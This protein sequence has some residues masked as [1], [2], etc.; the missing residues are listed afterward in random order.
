MWRGSIEPGLSPILR[1]PSVEEEGDGG[2]HR[3]ELGELGLIQ[4]SLCS[5]FGNHFLEMSYDL[6]AARHHRFNF[7][8]G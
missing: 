6:V 1:V 8:L 3:R 2:L 5:L 7:G 4:D